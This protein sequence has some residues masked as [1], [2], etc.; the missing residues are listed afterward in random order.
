MQKET[1]YRY[2]DIISDFDAFLQAIRSERITTV[3]W[4][5]HKVSR[6]RLI[7]EL[8]ECFACVEPVRWYKHA[9]RLGYEEKPGKTLYH[10]LGHYYIQEES[11]MIAALALNP[12][13]HSVVL[14]MCAAPG[15]KTTQLSALMENTGTIIANDKAIPRLK[16]L[17]ANVSRLACLNVSITWNDATKIQAKECFDYVLVDAPCTAEGNLQERITLMPR[18]MRES[19]SRLQ[20]NLLAKACE[21]VKPKGT[22]VYCTCTFAPE[23]NERVVSS[24]L[25]KYDVKLEPLKLKV[26]HAKGIESFGKEDYG[27]EMRKTARIYPHH[28]NSG[29]AYIAKL[30][31]RG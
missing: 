11:A 22:I 10:I 26:P 24:I 29:G 3:R 19:L 4:N 15:G 23:E 31:K 25:E 7:E 21:L 13:K 5:P 17:V 12:R 30:K 28:L 16:S 18:R 27:N 1:L 20:R 8:E 2:K 14:D 9:F 6:A